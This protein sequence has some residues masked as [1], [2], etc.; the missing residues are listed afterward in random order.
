MQDFK[1]VGDGVGFGGESLMTYDENMAVSPLYTYY[2]EDSG[3]APEGDGWYDEDGA[4][5]DITFEPGD[6]FVIQC[7]GDCTLEITKVVD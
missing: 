6:G 3:A 2:I 7:N 1:P 5:A 4:K